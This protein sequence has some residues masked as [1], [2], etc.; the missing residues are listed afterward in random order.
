MSKQLNAWDTQRG[1]E[2]IAVLDGADL[3]GQLVTL[4]TLVRGYFE[5]WP[6]KVGA[7]HRDAENIRHTIYR[8]AARVLMVQ[9]VVLHGWYPESKFWFELNLGTEGHGFSTSDERDIAA[10]L[11]AGKE[12]G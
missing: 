7:I 1:E 12:M 4:D 10:V 8:N 9:Q 2:A 3:L 5:I 11:A 6:H